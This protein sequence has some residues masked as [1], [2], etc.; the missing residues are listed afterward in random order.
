MATRFTARFGDE[1][2]G[3][4]ALRYGGGYIA[5]MKERNS[6][7]F[8]SMSRSAGASEDRGMGVLGGMFSW[9]PMRLGAIDYYTQDTINIFYTEGKVGMNRGADFEATLA[10]QF[11]AQNST[12]TNLLNGGNLLCHQPV[13]REGPDSASTTRS[14]RPPTP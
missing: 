12:G 4:P 8:I 11:A 10:G 5:A 14:S 9:G 7:E 3:G 6:T 2:S 13:R 1:A